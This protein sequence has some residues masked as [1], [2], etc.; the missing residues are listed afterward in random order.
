M[1]RFFSSSS[2]AQPACL[3]SDEHDMGASAAQPATL[4][5]QVEQSSA[6]QPASTS[7]EASDSAA[8][9]ATLMEQVVQI[10][11]YPKFFRRPASE[12][13]RQENSLAEKISKQ[14]KKLPKD[15]QQALLDR[16]A[17]DKLDEKAKLD[18]QS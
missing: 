4:M 12:Q 17:K 1:Q 9:P 7:A 14:W 5:E 6:A 11:H 18:A 16:K 8:Q 2:A 15:M 3:T 10:G 13:E